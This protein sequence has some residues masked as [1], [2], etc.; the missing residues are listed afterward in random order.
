M[1]ELPEVETIR[2]GLDKEVKGKRIRKVLIANEKAIKAPSSPGEFVRRIEGRTFSEIRRRGKCLILELD[3]EDSLIIHLRLT[4][5]L[6][7][8][9]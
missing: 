2:E 4:G 6:I 7:Y 9:S 8:S 5:R 3:S 1:P